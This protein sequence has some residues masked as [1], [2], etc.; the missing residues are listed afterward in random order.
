M[1]IAFNSEYLWAGQCRP[2]N[3][4]SMARDFETYDFRRNFVRYVVSLN[5]IN[6]A[7]T[8]HIFLPFLNRER[9]PQNYNYRAS[10]PEH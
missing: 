2:H 9:M 10:G 6:T 4:R 8:E 1:D 3:V 7:L 5:S